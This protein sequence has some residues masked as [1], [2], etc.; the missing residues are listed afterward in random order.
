MLLAD[1]SIIHY[2]MVQGSLEH[3]LHQ[4]PS[5]EAFGVAGDL[6]EVHALHRHRNA[7]GIL[8]Q[9]DQALG[10]IG[11]LELNLLLKARAHRG[12]QDLDLIGGGDGADP[13]AVGYAIHLCE[14]GVD[15]LRDIPPQILIAPIQG[16]GIQLVYEYD[17]GGHLLCLFIEAVN[18]SGAF[19][20]ELTDEAG[21]LDRQ[22]GNACLH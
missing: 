15:D 10:G 22:H 18:L 2:S 14:Q 11:Q 8:L 20:H 6:P 12:I 7:G 1:G 3:L 4:I 9:Q 17:A 13:F 5:R 21:G 19:T 16:N